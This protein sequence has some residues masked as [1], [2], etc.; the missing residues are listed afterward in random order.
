M[1]GTI[2][3]AK[4]LAT[5]ATGHVAE[6]WA[7]L[8]EVP[9]AQDHVAAAWVVLDELRP[10]KARP[11]AIHALDQAALVVEVLDENG[12]LHPS[13]IGAGAHIA[14][15]L[16]C[17]KAKTRFATKGELREYHAANTRLSDWELQQ[18]EGGVGDEI[19]ERI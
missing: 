17:L 8:Y 18:I 12:R 14:A 15:A 4:K 16:R 6:A 11:Q 10:V 1:S 19:N 5:E 13:A 2:H 9:A 7:L 3:I